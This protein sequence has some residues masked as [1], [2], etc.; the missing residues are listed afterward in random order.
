M[1][2]KVINQKPNPLNPVYI[3]S[4]KG[5][6]DVNDYMTKVFNPTLRLPMVPTNVVNIEIDGQNAN[7]DEINR[8]MLRCCTGTVDSEAED[9]CRSLF[10]QALPFYNPNTKLLLKDLFAVA[11]G[12][13]AGL[14]EPSAVVIYTPAMDII[15]AAS[16]FLAGTTEYA[17]FFATFAYYCRFE[18]FGVYFVN[19][20]AFNDFKAWFQT[21]INLIQNNLTQECLSLIADFMTL[22]LSGLTES[23]KIRNDETDNNDEYSF[24]RVLIAELMLYFGNTQLVGI[25]PFDF[26]NLFCPKNIVFINVEKFAHSSPAAIATEIKDINQ[27]ISIAQNVNMISNYKLQKLAPIARQL[28][29][30]QGMAIQAALSSPSKNAMRT[31]NIAFKKRI[32]TKREYLT[33][34]FRI[35]EKMKTQNMT[36]NIYK[37]VKSSFAKPNRRNPDDYN[38]QGKIVST[39][40]RPDLHLY[41]D[42]SGSI[43]EENYEGS[44]K[45]AIQ[46]AK[47]LNVNLY[48]NTF[49]HI[50]SQTVLLKCANKSVAQIYK[51]FMKTPKVTGGTDFEQVWHFINRSKKR[52]AELSVMVTDFEWNAR[53][54]FIKHPK[55][56]YYIPCANM[57]WH[58]ICDA[59]KDFAKSCEHN[60]P[61]IRAHILA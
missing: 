10:H 42:T 58:S 35:I 32:M 7:D 34:I 37:C 8:L 18:A 28:R 20:T 55:N 15:P 26:E 40:Y 24:A 17:E 59:A 49:S 29:K 54:A 23:F 48:I 46:L 60:D 41:L 44:V 51:E 1:N 22:T 6:F 31:A 12:T 4:F 27:S 2:V 56:L 5:N 36:Q 39:K 47:K 33:N 9:A 25:M 11:C 52:E 50:M 30:T 21:Q 14:D 38:L 19:E 13:E 45:L 61:N 57:N 53:S 16:G 3:P 43:S